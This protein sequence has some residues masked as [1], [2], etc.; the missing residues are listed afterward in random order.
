MMARGEVM[1]ASRQGHELPPGVGLGPDGQPTTDPDRVL[2]G[3]L[4][5]FGGYKGSALSMMVELLSAGLI[6]EGWLS[7]TEAFFAALSGLKGADSPA[8]DATP[9]APSHPTRES[10]FRTA[11]IKRSWPCAKRIKGK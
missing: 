8:T 3:V 9:Y 2:Q 11:C 1:L 6:G 7:H 10:K 5:P 4:L